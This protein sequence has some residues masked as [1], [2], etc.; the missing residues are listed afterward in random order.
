VPF[1]D[2]KIFLFTKPSFFFVKAQVLES[3]M[4]TGRLMK[5]KHISVSNVMSGSNTKFVNHD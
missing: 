5:S 1:T 4:Y 2:S 3:V